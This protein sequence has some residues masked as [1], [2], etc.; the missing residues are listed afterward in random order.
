VTTL[1]L[2]L[3]EGEVEYGKIMLKPTLAEIQQGI[4]GPCKIM[5][6]GTQVLLQW[7]CDREGDPKLFTSWY[8]R[9]ASDKDVVKQV[10]LLSGC[11]FGVAQSIMEF[12]DRF[13]IYEYL[14]QYDMAEE[15]KDFLSNEPSLELIDDQL[16]KLDT[17]EKQMKEMGN[18]VIGVVKVVVGHFQKQIIHLISKWKE[19]YTKG[20]LDDVKATLADLGQWM[21]S[22]TMQL[23]GSFMNLE[24]VQAAMAIIHTI[25][26]KECVIDWVFLT[27]TLI[28]TLTLTLTLIGRKV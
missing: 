10:L 14:W 6:K 23:G 24:E 17:L 16:A 21:R 25:R 15:C 4:N 22:V 9:L 11:F 8:S 18:T 28:L 13:K 7:G 5:V 2:N 1:E 20:L 19:E 27:L 12:V 26:E 3:G